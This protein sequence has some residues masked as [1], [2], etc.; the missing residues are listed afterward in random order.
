MD[1]D[2]CI[3][4][5]QESLEIAEQVDEP[6]RSKLLELANAWIALADE[7]VTPIPPEPVYPPAKSGDR[8]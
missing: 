2:S 5:A 8:H 6:H 3:K 1:R 4:R 7:G